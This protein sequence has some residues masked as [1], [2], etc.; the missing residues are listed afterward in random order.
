[1]SATTSE[2]RQPKYFSQLEIIAMAAHEA[3]RAYCLSIGDTSQVH[4]EEAPEW[5]RES[6]RQ[7]V[8]GILEGKLKSAEQG[9]ES[10]LALKRLQGWSYGEAKDVEKK[11]HPAFV[12][13][14]DLP[15]EQ[16]AKGV[17]CQGVV[18]V[19]ANVLNVP[20]AP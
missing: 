18:R 3:N 11:T 4:W 8:F 9:H 17:L 16:R 6:V 1:M 19:M 15:L 5:Q 7:G 13:W 20:I 14:S 2:Y 10:W 12:P